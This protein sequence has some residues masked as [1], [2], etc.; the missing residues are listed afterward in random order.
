MIAQFFRLCEE[1]SVPVSMDKTE[2]GTTL[3]I[4]LGILLNGNSMTLSIPDEK[5]TSAISHLEELA[6][7]QKA[8]I[9]D[10]QKLCRCLNFLSK[11]IFPGRTF[12][13]RMYSKYSRV[14]NIGGSPTNA[15]EFKL[16]QYHHVRL[17]AEFKLDC[18][19]WLN[20]L[21]T[22]PEIQKVV[23]RPMVDHLAE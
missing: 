10:L 3:I 19:V 9:R 20:F 2:W 12:I 14:V 22:D 21:K 6:H 17:D 8:T 5:R 13:R 18:H 23:C 1:I 15:A 11:A 16:K 4:F 7:R